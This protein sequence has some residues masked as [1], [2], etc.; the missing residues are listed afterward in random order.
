MPTRIQQQVADFELQYNSTRHSGQNNVLDNSP[1]L[2][3][4]SL[5]E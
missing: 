1:H 3:K 2:K 5:Y 4:E